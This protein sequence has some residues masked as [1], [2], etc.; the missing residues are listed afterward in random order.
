MEE[1]CKALIA[2]T[3]R[4]L[5]FYECKRMPFGLANAPAT[6]QH[7]MQ[8]YLGNLHLQ[9]C[10]IY[11]ADIIVFSKTP[12]EHLVRLRAVF[13]QLKK[14]ELKLKPL[15]CEFF[16]QKLTC[17]GHVVSTNGIQTDSKKEEA[18]WKWSIPTKVTE[19]H[20]FLGF[21]NYYHRFIKKYAQVAKPLYKLI[22]G[23]NMARK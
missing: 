3:L 1:D 11:L 16:K 14:A 17:L 13:E 18:I 7:L 22:S 23:E 6:F 15:K 4:P 2:F 5:G 20:C 21:A 12:E 19:V 8:S 10:I 9:Y